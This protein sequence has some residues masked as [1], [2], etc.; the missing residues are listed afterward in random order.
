VKKNRRK[1]STEVKF[2]L[3][4][5]DKFLS[6]IPNLFSDRSKSSVLKQRKIF[7]DDPNTNIKK[8]ESELQPA[9]K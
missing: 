1:R 9:L 2:K 8:P 7:S 3:K 4:K 5:N 6:P